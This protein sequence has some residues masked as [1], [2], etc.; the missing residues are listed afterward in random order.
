MLHIKEH[1]V[2]DGSGAV[3]KMAAPVECKGIIG[4][5]DRCVRSFTKASG[6]HIFSALYSV[7]HASVS[8]HV[9]NRRHDIF[10]YRTLKRTMVIQSTFRRDVS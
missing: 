7:I 2:L 1:E 10:H 6:N 3:V 5:D 9:K 4:S 8:Y